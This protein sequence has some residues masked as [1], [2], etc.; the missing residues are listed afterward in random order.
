M[1]MITEFGTDHV[2]NCDVFNEVRPTQPDPTFI[3]SVGQA[4]FNA[5]TVS[6]VDAVW[7]KQF[8]YIIV[9]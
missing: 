8:N 9:V 5:M 1:Q 2:Y 3:T 6:D 7:L 4:V